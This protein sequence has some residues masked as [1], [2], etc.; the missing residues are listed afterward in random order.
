MTVSEVKGKAVNVNGGVK[1]S[2]S[3]FGLGFNDASA[4]AKKYTIADTETTVSS[5]PAKSFVILKK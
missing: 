5:V 1:L 3:Y 4:S 2:G